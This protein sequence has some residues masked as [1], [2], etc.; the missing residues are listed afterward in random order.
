MS[1]K[2]TLEKAAQICIVFKRNLEFYL[3]SIKLS[4]AVTLFPA[5]LISP[6]VYQSRTTSAPLFPYSFPEMLIR[7]AKLNVLTHDC[8]RLIDSIRSLR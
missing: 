4:C 8:N 2:R 5:M 1:K 3:A 6:K 7:S